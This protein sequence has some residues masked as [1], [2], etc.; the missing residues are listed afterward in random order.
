ML[1]T[2]NQRLKAFIDSLNNFRITTPDEL[3][4]ILDCINMYNFD[5]IQADMINETKSLDVNLYVEYLAI[6][7]PEFE[8]LKHTQN[9]YFGDL[10][11]PESILNK[12]NNLLKDTEYMTLIHD[13]MKKKEINESKINDV[14]YPEVNNKNK[15]RIHR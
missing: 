10:L 3:L 5:D 11:L 15:R 4:E 2:I 8:R 1:T 9:W 12:M 13:I 7:T 6:L 14:L